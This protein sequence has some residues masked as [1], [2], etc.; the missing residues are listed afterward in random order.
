M[1]DA[2]DWLDAEREALDAC[3]RRA[4]RYEAALRELIE[5]ALR[6]ERQ[7]FYVHD[8]GRVEKVVGYVCEGTPDYWWC[9]SV[10]VSAAVGYRLFR[11]RV[12]AYERAYAQARNALNVAQ[13]NL[14]RIERERWS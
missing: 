4:A 7:F 1:S 6:E 14:A 12:D 10:G 11:D 3:E 8:D 5:A 13:A 2:G 9:P